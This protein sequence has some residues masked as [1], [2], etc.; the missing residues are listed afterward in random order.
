MC[1][2]LELDRQGFGR[3]PDVVVGY[4]YGQGF[5]RVSRGERKRAAAVRIVFAGGRRAVGGL[6]WHRQASCAR[7]VQHGGEHHAARIFADRGTVRIQPGC[8]IV[9]R[10]RSDRYDALLRDF[11]PRWIVEHEVERFVLF[12][13][14]V[15]D[16]RHAD[17]LGR[18][19]VCE[20][21]DSRGNRVIRTWCRRALQSS[22]GGR[23]GGVGG[24]GGAGRVTHRCFSVGRPH[25]E[26]GDV[27]DPI[28]LAG[29]FISE[30][31]TVDQGC[32]H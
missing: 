1:D 14:A 27:D 10:Y 4:G 19:S 22:A 17:A 6:P 2:L 30:R 11:K 18:F 26:N 21:D 9:I 12:V 8:R 16:Q 7:T 31:L 15:V 13:D 3:F 28:S 20:F 5:A 24:G 29:G 32:E 23:G 25:A